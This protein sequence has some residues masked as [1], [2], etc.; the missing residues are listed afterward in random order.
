MVYYLFKGEQFQFPRTTTTIVFT[1]FW[2]WH[3]SPLTSSTRTSRWTIKTHLQTYCKMVWGSP[4]Y[5]TRGTEEPGPIDMRPE[6]EPEPPQATAPAWNI[7]LWLPRLVHTIINTFGVSH[8]YICPP[9][10][11]PD[12]DIDL[13]GM[14]ADVSSKIWKVGEN[15]KWH[16]LTISEYVLVLV[17]QLVL[18]WG[19]QKVKN[20]AG[21]A[22]RHIIGAWFWY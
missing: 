2:L 10:C 8:L 17:C 5:A 11:I 14:V 15:S 7:L 22:S 13:P 3:T 16:N 1:C 21:Q 19:P 18:E 4:R 9:I 20:R 6:P 12:M